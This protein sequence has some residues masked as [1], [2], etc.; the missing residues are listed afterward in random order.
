MVGVKGLNDSVLRLLELVSH[1]KDWSELVIGELFIK[2]NNLASQLL[3]CEV[4]KIITFSCQV[5]NN[6]GQEYR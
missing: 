3:K 1:N 6:T 2:Y 5:V 4:F